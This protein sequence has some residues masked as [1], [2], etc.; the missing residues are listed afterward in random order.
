[1]HFYYVQI[2]EASYSTT[3]KFNCSIER[4]FKTP[5][6]GDA[7][8]FLYGYGPIPAVIKFIKDETWGNPGGS[9]IP[10]FKRNFFFKGGE[11][12]FDEVFE[13]IEN[14]YWKWGVS[15]FGPLMFF[16]THNIGEWW[17]IQNNDNTITATYKYTYFA[18]NIFAQPLNWLFVKLFWKPLMNNAMKQM[19]MFAEGNISFLYS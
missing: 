8:K 2:M 13:R 17:C 3:Q 10:I 5:I 7:T 15:N 16:A 19:K 12:G 1:M 18:K 14:K 9:R 4:A 11:F 6:L